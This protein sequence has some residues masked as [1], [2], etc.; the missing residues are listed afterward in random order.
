MPR[1]WFSIQILSS[2]KLELAKMSCQAGGWRPAFV[3]ADACTTHGVKSG[4]DSCENGFPERKWWPWT[5]PSFF[6]LGSK[7]F[8][9]MAAIHSARLCGSFGKEKRRSD[10][11]SILHQHDECRRSSHMTVAFSWRDRSTS[12]QKKQKNSKNKSKELL[13]PAPQRPLHWA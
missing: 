7:S 11:G 12:K 13:W 2:R 1:R 5:R 4:C 6:V 10:P 9:C 8:C 3:F